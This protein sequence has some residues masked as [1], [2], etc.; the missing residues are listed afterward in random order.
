MDT[1]AFRSSI[2]QKLA[3]EY[4]LLDERNVLY[5]RHYRNSLGSGV[6]RPVIGVTFWLRGKRI[7]TG[8]SVANREKLTTKFLIGRSDL[9][10]FAVKA[11][12]EKHK[13]IA[14]K[15]MIQ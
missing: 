9:D 8:V 2:D 10:G 14:L 3:E 4:G 13:K 12:A 5:Y 15:K 1:G 11:N 6:R 7:T